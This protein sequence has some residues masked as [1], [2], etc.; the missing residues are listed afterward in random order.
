MAAAAA[1]AEV[2][3]APHGGWA[4]RKLIPDKGKRGLWQIDK[5]HGQRIP[6]CLCVCVANEACVGNN[7]RRRNWERNSHPVMKHVAKDSSARAGNWIDTFGYGLEVVQRQGQT[8]WWRVDEAVPR[9]AGGGFLG[10][11]QPASTASR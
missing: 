10:G 9:C 4:Q 2:A 5:R 8:G 7:E 6:P 3:P 1:A 11:C